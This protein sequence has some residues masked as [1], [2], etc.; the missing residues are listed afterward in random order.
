VELPL[1]RS[2][3]SPELFRVVTAEDVGRPY[4]KLGIVHAPAS[5][6]EREAIAALKRRART[7]GGDALL[8][9]RRQGSGSTADRA[10][11]SL[12]DAPWEAAVIV[13]TDGRAGAA[14]TPPPGAPP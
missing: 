7:L 1:D 8:D 10:S 3:R 5:L 2:E 12:A 4:R 14:P 13:W 9:V 11:S 6:S